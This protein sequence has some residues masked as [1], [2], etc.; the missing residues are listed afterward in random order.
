MASTTLKVTTILLRIL[1]CWDVTLYSTVNRS[2]FVKG[3]YCF[4]VQSWGITREGNICFKMLGSVNSTAHHNI[5]EDQRLPHQCHGDLGLTIYLKH[6]I[7]ISY[8]CCL[9]LMSFAC[10]SRF[11]SC[12]H[13]NI[14]WVCLITS[15]GMLH[16]FHYFNI[17]IKKNMEHQL[18]PQIFHIVFQATDTWLAE[19]V[20][21]DLLVKGIKEAVCNWNK[22][23]LSFIPC[24]KYFFIGSKV[25]AMWQMTCPVKLLLKFCCDM[26][27]MI[28][29]TVLVGFL[30]VMQFCAVMVCTYCWSVI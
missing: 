27:C 5:P 4:H 3:T 23:H 28:L 15:R 6:V 17:G 9:V 30:L 13:K 2:W 12:K 14:M 1:V 24:L 18:N 20:S 11:W 21:P 22:Y 25:Q 19:T 10:I 8:S 26:G 7:R 16:S 29:G